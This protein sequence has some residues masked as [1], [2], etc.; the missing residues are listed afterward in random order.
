MIKAA[1]IEGSNGLATWI[2]ININT[3]EPEG[4]MT[5]SGS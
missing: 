1:S 3:S 4:V 2:S 5:I